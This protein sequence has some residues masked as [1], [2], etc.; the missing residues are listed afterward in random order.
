MCF[1]ASIPHTSLLSG[2]QLVSLTDVFEHVPGLWD[3][4]RVVQFKG[5]IGQAASS[6]TSLIWDI[7]HLE[8]GGRQ[9]GNLRLF[10]PADRPTLEFHLHT[11]MQKIAASLLIEFKKWVLQAESSG[12][13]LKTPLDSQAGLSS[14]EVIKAKKWRL[15]RAQKTIGDYCLLAGS[16]VDA[17]AHYSILQ[18]SSISEVIP[19]QPTKFQCRTIMSISINWGSSQQAVVTDCLLCTFK[20]PLFG[21]DN[22]RFHKLSKINQTELQN[23]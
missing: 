10:P 3:V 8:E 11:M 14:E 20:S 2:Y 9:G 4:A 19:S 16:P 13:I 7:L 1:L 5:T 18:C 23:K 22:L 15:E 21:L 6:W 17:N 12:T